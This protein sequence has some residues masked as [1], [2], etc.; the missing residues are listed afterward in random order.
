M[1]KYSQT[2]RNKGCRQ[3][4]YRNWVKD[5]IKEWPD[6]SRAIVCPCSPKFSKGSHFVRNYKSLS[7]SYVVVTRNEW[8]EMKGELL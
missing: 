2:E 3:K 1:T 5:N 8:M 6:E 7:Y 4:S